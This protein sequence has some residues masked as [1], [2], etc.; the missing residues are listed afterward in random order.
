MTN[1]KLRFGVIGCADIAMKSVIP[2][3]QHRILRKSSPSPVAKPTK[4]QLRR[5]NL[6]SHAHMGAMKIC[7]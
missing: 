4:R 7:S 6:A 2:G 1:Q 5:R 3:I